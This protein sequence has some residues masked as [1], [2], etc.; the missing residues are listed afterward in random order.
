MLRI[1]ITV[2]KDRDLDKGTYMGSEVQ[3][4]RRRDREFGWGTSLAVAL[5]VLYGFSSCRL[6]DLIPSVV[7]AVADYRFFI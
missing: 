6:Y 3:W 1:V 2:S 7:A 5:F 4:S